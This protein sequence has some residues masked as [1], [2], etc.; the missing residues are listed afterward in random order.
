MHYSLDYGYLQIVQASWLQ[1]K[2][3]R[4]QATSR[5]ISP[6]RGIIYD[7]TGKVL[8]ASAQVDTVT[9]DPSRIKEENK[10]K[11]AK[12]FS[13]IFTLDYEETLTKVSSD[14][15]IET[16]AK[17]VEKDKIDALKNWMSENK[18][19][20]GINIDADVKR[21]Y[22]Y[23]NVASNLIGFCDTDNNGQDGL[24]LK[25]NSVLSGTP[26]KI[27]T[28]E[29]AVS[30]LIPN[31]D[32]SYTAPENG[33]NITLTIDAHI[34]TITEKYLKQACI[35]NDAKKGGTV[36][37]MK[38]STG[39]ILAM[40]SY[41]DYDL[42]NPRTPID[43]LKETW[44]TLSET[45]QLNYLYQMWRNKAVLNTYEPGSVFKTITAAIGLEEGVTDTDIPNDFVC[46]GHEIIDGVKISCWKY[47]TTHGYQTLREALMN[48]CNPALMQLSKRIGKTSMYKYLK[49]LGLMDKT[50]IATP[51]EA[52]SNFWDFEDVGNVELATMSFGQ[53]FNITP[54][55][56]VTAISCIANNGV[57]MQPRIVKQI[58]NADTGAITTLEPVA[59][60]TVF[61]KETCDKMLDML[62]S[63]VD[64][65]TGYLGQVKGYSVGGKTGTSEPPPG[66]NEYTASFVAIAPI[67][68][69]ELVVLVTQYGLPKYGNHQGGRL[70]GPV[71]AG[72]LKEVLP[73]LEIPSNDSTAIT[74]TNTSS[75]LLPDVRNKTAAEAKQ[76]LE[77][78]GFTC[79][80]SGNDNSLIVTDQVPKPGIGLTKGSIISLYTAGNETR[81]SKQV[82]NLKNMTLTQAKQALKNLNLNISVSGTTGTVVSQDPM[83]GTAVEEGSIVSIDLN[84]QNRDAH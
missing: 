26:G 23:N 62:L 25:W 60:R 9:I 59:V 27:V 6:K 13:E 12:A 84:N 61:S 52:N 80:I 53:R 72:I 7:S 16:I 55:Q 81:I 75:I 39:D 14:S 79:N 73:Y 4:Q 24:E 29:D 35:E 8:A 71:A 31:K 50:G 83:A 15:R 43:S 21:Y 65:G 30:D 48:S 57:L 28:I 70:C 69:P 76:T 51:S 5:I 41:P 63:V 40:A 67:E 37:V 46:R 68:N 45:E 66:S 36:V 56:L 3:S 44:D 54:I 42:N 19:Y 82:P 74:V 1:E 78:L 32:E 18:M 11:V 33:S 38:P 17:K 22:P 20:S 34:Q 2:A 47:T 58:E 77:N 64:D 49:A 10:E